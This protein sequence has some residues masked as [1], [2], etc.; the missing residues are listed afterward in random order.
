MNIDTKSAFETL[1]HLLALIRRY[2]CTTY[3]YVKPRETFV[4]IVAAS[5]ARNP[6]TPMGVSGKPLLIFIALTMS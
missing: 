2:N 4:E 1:G 3:I 6:L 5:G